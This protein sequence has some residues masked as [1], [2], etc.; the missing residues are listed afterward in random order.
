MKLHN[1]ILKF[2]LLLVIF[3][4][5]LISC[6]D[7]NKKDNHK[8]SYINKS[9]SNEVVSKL[10]YDSITGKLMAKF[11]TVDDTIVIGQIKEYKYHPNGVLYKDITYD[12]TWTEI[13]WYVSEYDSF[14]SLYKRKSYWYSRG[15]IEIC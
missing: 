15:V 8:L 6:K 12:S 1:K 7:S 4:S 5:C 11:K 13:I 9:K 14:G 2:V 10:F 3:Y